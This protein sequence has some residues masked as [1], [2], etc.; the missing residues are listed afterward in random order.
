MCLRYSILF[1]IALM[2]TLPS[3]TND[4]KQAHNAKAT[5]GQKL[6][7]KVVVAT[8]QSLDETI[9]TTGTLLANEKI[10]LASEV[11]G[12]ITR[13]YFREG[14]R[15]SRGQLLV[16]LDDREL[17]AEVQKAR[18][19]KNLMIEKE[20]RQKHLLGIGAISREEY[21]A[22]LNTLNVLK[23]QLMLLEA[24][25][26]KTELRA[27]FDGVMGLRN[28]SEG[29]AISPG[30][31]I[32][33]LQNINPLKLEFSVPEK[34]S[35]SIQNGMKVQFRLQAFDSLFTAEVYAIE[36]LLEAATRTLRVRALFP[37]PGNKVLPGA[38]ADMSLSP[39][40]SRN[41]F[42]IPSQA[43]V[44][45]AQGAFVFILKN[46]KVD[47]RRVETAFRTRAFVELTSGLQAGDTILTSALLQL[48]KGMEVEAIQDES[49][50][51]SLKEQ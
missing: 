34:Y 11:A 49:G 33:S 42:L 14:E 19:E 46:G 24:R 38:F 37:N 16:K 50:I 9:H 21:D 31:S 20:S 25:L 41:T 17:Q 23:A 1:V 18:Y 32:A 6:K 5:G 28:V 35:Q 8:P 29:A 40:G 51:S 30:I 12:R 7:V 44:P 4:G 45:D 2:L 47:I 15:V 39:Q 26:D 10:D 13:I 3:C 36:P 48:R 43:L 22:S 27:P